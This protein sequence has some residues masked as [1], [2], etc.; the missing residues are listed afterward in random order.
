V[1]QRGFDRSPLE[2]AEEAG[3]VKAVQAAAIK[4]IN[5]PLP[6]GGVQYWSDAALLSSVGIPSVLIGPSGGGAHADEEWVDLSSVRTCAEIYLATAKE[7]C[8]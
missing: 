2:T 4:V 8:G 6:I 3:I 1:I 5:R 7:F